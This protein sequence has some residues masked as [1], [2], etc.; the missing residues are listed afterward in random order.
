MSERSLCWNF[1]LRNGVYS[2]LQDDVVILFW[3]V[4]RCPIVEYIHF[5]DWQIFSEIGVICLS[6]LSWWNDLLQND[7]FTSE[8]DARNGHL[9]WI[10]QI[11]PWHLMP[12]SLVVMTWYTTVEYGT[13]AGQQQFC[14]GDQGDWP[15]LPSLP[16]VF[17]FIYGGDCEHQTGAMG[18]HRLFRYLAFLHYMVCW[19]F[20]RHITHWLYWRLCNVE[21]NFC[22]PLLFMSWNCFWLIEMLLE[23]KHEVW[24]S[25][26][27]QRIIV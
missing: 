9:G 6:Q 14:F 2:S 13:L 11:C 24:R 23:I 15:L 22:S 10:T 16:M 3:L 5:C 25:S 7:V 27:N 26:V 18:L 4:T 19:W 20:Q 8:F 1:D 12:S 21:Q 17:V